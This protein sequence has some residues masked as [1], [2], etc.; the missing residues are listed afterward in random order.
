MTEIIIK[1]VPYNKNDN[2][3]YSAVSLS[4]IIILII[5]LGKIVKTSPI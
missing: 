1:N 5:P 2:G 4:Y 3:F